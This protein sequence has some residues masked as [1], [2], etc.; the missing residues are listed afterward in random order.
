MSIGDGWTVHRFTV[1]GKYRG[2]AKVKTTKG[3][4]YNKYSNERIERGATAV[5]A[6]PSLPLMTSQSFWKI[7]L[8][9]YQRAERNTSR[10]QFPSNAHL[11]TLRDTTAKS[12]YSRFSVGNERAWPKYAVGCNRGPVEHAISANT[13]SRVGLIVYHT[14]HWCR[15]PQPTWWHKTSCR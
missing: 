4:L 8:L 12:K 11:I 5:L 14:G 10:V 9:L 7:V 6:P 3:R 1:D 13:K 2:V 15:A